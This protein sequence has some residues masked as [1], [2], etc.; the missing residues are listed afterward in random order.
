MFS[1]CTVPSDIK[2]TKVT[3]TDQEASP[4]ASKNTGVVLVPHCAWTTMVIGGGIR[5]CRCK[6]RPMLVLRRQKKCRRKD[7]H[8]CGLSFQVLQCC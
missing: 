6:Y 1:G 4:S 3:S 7:F 8:I 2:D 5:Q